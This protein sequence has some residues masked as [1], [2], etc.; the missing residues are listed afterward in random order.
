[1][2]YAYGKIMNEPADTHKAKEWLRAMLPE[3]NMA[4]RL[5]EQEH[6]SP[7][8]A[9]ESQAILELEKK[10]CEQKRCLECNIGQR[11]LSETIMLP[12]GQSM[13]NS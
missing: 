13:N 12:A 2:L 6:W 7:A 8:N 1:M 3:R 10:Y 9:L 4:T 5:F 11:M